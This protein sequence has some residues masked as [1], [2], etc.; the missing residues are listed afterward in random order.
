MP[1]AYDTWLDRSAADEAADEADERR[2]EW[3]AERTA[4]L[5]AA[6]LREDEPV[7]EALDA[8]LADDYDSRISA[9]L[10]RFLL[11]CANTPSDRSRD[12]AAL[13]LESFLRPNVEARIR[14]DAESDAAAEFDRAERNAPTAADARMEAAA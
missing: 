1:A 2:E 7:Q 6:R 9:A 13:E 3:I 4:E 5:T 11:A 8:L 12:A 14:D 10:R